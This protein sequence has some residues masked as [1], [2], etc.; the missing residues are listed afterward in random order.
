[1]SAI[2]RSARF[3]WRS[4]K[5]FWKSILIAI[6]AISLLILIACLL[7]YSFKGVNILDQSALINYSES[8]LH[9]GSYTNEVVFTGLASGFISVPKTKFLTTLA[10][11]PPTTNELYLNSVIVARVVEGTKLQISASAQC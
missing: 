3:I 11:R 9:D 4:V 2:R 1:M 8:R 5:R 10:D 7:I 6:L